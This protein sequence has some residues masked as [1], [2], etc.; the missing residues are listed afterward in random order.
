MVAESAPPAP[1]AS[2]GAEPDGAPLS[3]RLARAR[4]YL[5]R[6]DAA[7]A[8]LFLDIHLS[9]RPDDPDALALKGLALI[10]QGAVEDGLALLARHAGADAPV[11]RRLLHGQGL[12]VAG[13]AAD[14]ATLFDALTRRVRGEVPA[15]LGLISARRALGDLEGAHAAAMDALMHTPPDAQAPILGLLGAVA[16]ERRDW[17]LA[18]EALARSTAAE[19]DPGALNNLGVA[20]QAVGDPAGAEEAYRASLALDPGQASTLN[21][22]GNVLAAQGRAADAEAAYRAACAARPAFVD[23]LYNL[24][25][26]LRDKGP[27]GAAEALDLVRA[28]LAAQPD[29]ARLHL[30][31][32]ATLRQLG[33]LDEALAALDRA[34][35]L[36]P[37]SV[38]AANT[39][40]LVLLAADR[41]HEALPWF[42]RALAGLDEG[43]DKT[44]VVLNNLGTLLAN[45]GRQE[46]GRAHLERAVALRPDYADAL[47]NLGH[48]CFQMDDFDAAFGWFNK[49]VAAAPDSGLGYFSRGLVLHSL[50]YLEEAEVEARKAL[51]RAPEN[52]LALNL[53]GLVLADRR[54]LPEAVRW[55]DKAASRAAAVEETVIFSNYLYTNAYRDDVDAAWLA[56]QHARYEAA[57]GGTDPDPARPHDNDRT[58]DR[59]LRVGYVS[60]DFR[61]H[62]VAFFI[63]PILERHDRDRFEVFC[64][65]GVVRPDW[66]TDRLRGLADHWRDIRGRGDLEVADT[67]RADGIDILVDLNGHTA[68][69]RLP[70]FL[71]KP[72]PVQVTYLGYPETTGLTAMDYRLTDGRA[73]PPGEADALAA[74][75]LV[76]LPDCFHLYRPP[77]DLAPDPAPWPPAEARPFTFGSFNNMMK[78]TPALVG[79]WA[80]IL[81]RTPGSRL[82]LKGKQM[83]SEVLRQDLL[84]EFAGHGIAADRLSLRPMIG[85]LTEHLALYGEVDLALDTF[86]YNGTTTTCEALYMGV[87]VLSVAGDRHAARVGA[88][89]LAALGLD[90]RLLARDVADY[91]DRAVALAADPEA[92]AGLRHGL[93]RRLLDSPLCDEVAFLRHLEDVY[94]DLWR[95]WCAGPPTTGRR[96]RVADRSAPPD[97]PVAFM[98]TL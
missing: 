28:R 86:P 15:W 78:V 75:T 40:G 22:L 57:Y 30:A 52:P 32:G 67:V 6:D 46:E 38:E 82:L 18:A 80:E 87:P 96:P 47:G 79:T 13:R 98:V 61:K 43:A 24:C 91:V 85:T 25:L 1:S 16:V 51:E 45:L 60:S 3:P 76:R 20:R 8:L 31:E 56:G 81:R 11:G 83:E 62:S 4:Q 36:D 65:S 49:L 39:R 68:H 72:A 92:L 64:Y 21:N 37:S 94:R 55:L 29:S 89:L 50:Q 63:E 58:P 69:N 84:S 73:D 41:P 33:R 95:R 93:R 70:V 9:G 77:A 27:E 5:A 10:H 71:H 19:P 59:R 48:L 88:S 17:A 53:L 2:E 23:A 97:Q 12:L 74:E 14:A 7:G 42:E 66:M 90:D 44:P 54:R 26:L 35:A 34:L